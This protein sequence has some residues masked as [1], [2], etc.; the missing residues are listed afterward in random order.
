MQ[1]S[2]TKNIKFWTAFLNASKKMLCVS[3][4]ENLNFSKL[5]DIVKLLSSIDV[6]RFM[7]IFC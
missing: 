4:P 1:N 2:Y 7:I 5:L 3:L 6:M